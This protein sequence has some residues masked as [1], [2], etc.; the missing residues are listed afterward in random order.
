VTRGGG[1]TTDIRGR[2]RAVTLPIILKPEEA[3]MIVVQWAVSPGHRRR[4]G[5]LL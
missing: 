5:V 1:S 4:R 3:G 2:G